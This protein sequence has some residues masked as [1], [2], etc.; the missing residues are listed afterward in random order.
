MIIKG[1]DKDYLSAVLR[2]MRNHICKTEILERHLLNQTRHIFI[3]R[4]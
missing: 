4:P 2:K 3:L 1:I